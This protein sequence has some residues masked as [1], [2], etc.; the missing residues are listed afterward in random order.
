M[1]PLTE[2]TVWQKTHHQTD[3]TVFAS[4]SWSLFLDTPIISQC[5]LQPSG[6]WSHDQLLRK[7]CLTRSTTLFISLNLDYVHYRAVL[8]SNQHYTPFGMFNCLTSDIHMTS[9]R[10]CDKPCVQC[11]LNSNTEF[12]NT[13]I[14]WREGVPSCAYLYMIHQVLCFF[15]S[16]CMFRAE[17][18]GLISHVFVS[19]V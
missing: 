19:T 17:S 9:L 8:R 10:C 4:S 6:Y 1:C 15:H 14:G 5:L 11:R 16:L 2:E 18:T 12:R 13:L 7:E 3:M